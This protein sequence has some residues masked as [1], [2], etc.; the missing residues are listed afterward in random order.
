MCA[1]CRKPTSRPLAKYCDGCRWKHRGKR[2][3][4]VWTPEKDAVMREK[5]DGRIGC[6]EPIAHAFGWPAWVIKR[7]AATL[8]LTKPKP[9]RDW[10]PEEEAFLLEHAGTRHV[11]WIAKKLGRTLASVAMKLKHEHMSRAIREGYTMRELETCFGVDHRAISRWVHSG[12]LQ[13]Q[14]RGYDTDRDA[15]AVTDAALVRFIMDN[16]MAFELRRVDQLWFMDLITGG[17][18]LRR[19]LHSAED[20]A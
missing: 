14:K 10:T 2:P 5:Y 3:M 16:P 1:D 4:Y 7:R 12:K 19:A 20:A 9:R 8:G 6:S 17:G 18:V 15:W 13:V 11:N